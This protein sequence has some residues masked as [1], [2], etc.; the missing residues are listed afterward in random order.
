MKARAQLL[1]DNLLDLSHLA[2]VHA[3]SVAGGDIALDEPEVVEEDGRLQVW[4]IRRD[5]PLAGFAKFLLPNEEGRVWDTMLTDVYSPG[6]IN[7][8]G[9]WVWRAQPDGSRGEP[10]GKLNFV[11][12]I[13]PASPT[14]THYLGIVTRN[15]A[16]DNDELSAMLVAQSDVVRGEDVTALEA[17]EKVADRY[18]DPAKEVSIKV[19]EGAIVMRRRMRRMIA[20]EHG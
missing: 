11:H 2:F 1:I 4:R 10:L 7:A 15:F 12:I 14:E 17:I 9:P 6:F 20:A 3:N 8:G 19:D 16:I 18:G 13:T 5:V